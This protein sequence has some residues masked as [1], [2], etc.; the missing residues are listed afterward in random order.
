[1]CIFPFSV[2]PTLQLFSTE[3][4]LSLEVSS[5]GKKKGIIEREEDVWNIP[6]WFKTVWAQEDGGKACCDD[7][8]L[9]TFLLPDNHTWSLSLGS[10]AF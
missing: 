8:M 10:K 1:M 9:L 6:E 7:Q 4:C 3:L 2:S 5:E